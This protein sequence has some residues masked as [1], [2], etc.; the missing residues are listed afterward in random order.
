MI[1][2]NCK[3]D[4]IAIEYNNIELDHCINCKGVWFDSG[5]LELFIESVNMEKPESLIK[6]IINLPEMKAPPHKRRKCPICGQGMTETAMGE[7]ELHVDVCQQGDGIWFDG[8]EVHQLIRQLKQKPSAKGSS[9][10]QIV[11]F[12]GEVFKAED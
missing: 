5:E 7:P 1:C 2:P 12:L 10:Q 4:M 8:G 9:Q 3:H 11:T 6:N